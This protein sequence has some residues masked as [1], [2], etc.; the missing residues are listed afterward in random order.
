MSI[1]FS[2]LVK[3]AR[4]GATSFLAVGADIGLMWWLAYSFSI[5]YLLA[6]AVGFC[7]GCLVK[8]LVSKYLV[9]DNNGERGETLTVTL[10]LLIAVVGLSVNHLIIFVGVEYLDVHLLLAK[11][12][13]A[14]FVFVLNFFLL[15]VF[16]FKDA[17]VIKVVKSS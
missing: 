13:S 10:F 5:S 17:E 1:K 6:A 14:G 15:G 7:V 3:M 11:I 12:F 16:V 8:Y 9:F 4:Y 2:L